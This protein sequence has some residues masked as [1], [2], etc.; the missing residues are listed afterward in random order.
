MIIIINIS[1]RKNV[2]I[3]L[4]CVCRVCIFTKRQNPVC[5]VVVRVH[6]RIY[7]VTVNTLKSLFSNKVFCVCGQDVTIL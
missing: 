5:K 7:C 3:L 6:H 4:V 2:V 1:N